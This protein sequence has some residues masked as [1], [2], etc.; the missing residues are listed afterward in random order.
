MTIRSLQHPL[1]SDRFLLQADAA[2]LFPIGAMPFGY[3]AL[4]FW[5]KSR[6]I[7]L[8]FSRRKKGIKAATRAQSTH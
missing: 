3:C 2:L 4:L 6:R 7:A 1:L 8:P 5:A